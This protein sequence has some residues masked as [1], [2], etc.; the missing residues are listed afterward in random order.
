MKL[1]TDPSTLTWDF[2]C[3]KITWKTSSSYSIKKRETIYLTREL[4]TLTLETL[5]NGFAWEK[6][7]EMCTG[8]FLLICFKIYIIPGTLN[9]IWDLKKSLSEFSTM[10]SKPDKVVPYPFIAEIK[11]SRGSYRQNKIEKSYLMMHFIE[12]KNRNCK[13]GFVLGQRDGSVG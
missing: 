4:K 12:S 2:P 5:T 3:V 1:L 7:Q 11:K 13:A 9:R 8:I 6:Q 10:Q